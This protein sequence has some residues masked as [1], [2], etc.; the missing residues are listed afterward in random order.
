MILVDVLLYKDPVFFRIRV[1]EKSRILWV[2]IRNT[3]LKTAVHPDLHASLGSGGR[4][5]PGKAG[6]GQQGQA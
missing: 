2:R 4:G 1:L 5:S 6:W 3:A